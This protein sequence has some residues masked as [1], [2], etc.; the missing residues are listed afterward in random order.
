IGAGVQEVWR[1]IEVRT[2]GPI[3]PSVSDL[4]VDF[5]EAGNRLRNVAVDKDARSA[6][7]RQSGSCRLQRAIAV[8]LATRVVI[9]PIANV[10]RERAP[11]RADTA[12]EVDFGS[13]VIGELDALTGEAGIK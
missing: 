11:R 5:V 12:V 10:E 4:A 9:V 7:P 13:R 3:G 6:I 2:E 8:A 1:V